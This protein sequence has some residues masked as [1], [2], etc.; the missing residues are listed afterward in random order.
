MKRL[1]PLL[2]ALLAGPMLAPGEA[3][4]QARGP[5]AEEIQE[6]GQE[7]LSRREREALQVEQEASMD[8]ATRALRLQEL[9]AWL[10]R[11]PGRYRIKGEVRFGQESG[12][13]DGVA[14]CSGVGDGPGVNCII[15]AKWPLLGNSNPMN[16]RP[17]AT[18]YLNTMRPSVLVFG[19][20]LYPP[21]VI[22]Q[23]VMGDS[24]VLDWSGSLE[25]DTLNQAADHRCTD[26]CVGEF[27]VTAAAASEPVTFEMLLFNPDYARF[28]RPDTLEN[29]I[30]FRMERDPEARAEKPLR[31]LRAR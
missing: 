9:D 27:N 29:H 14:D 4:A 8:E 19:M 26:R 12:S 22:T 15:N 17:S 11:L 24:V 18:E 7:I 30:T 20:S 16:V 3:L 1:A 25:E 2:L 21:R 31:A 6:S 13:V 23:M 5:D 10:R 28:D